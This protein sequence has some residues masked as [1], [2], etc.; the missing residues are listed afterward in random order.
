MTRIESSNQSTDVSEY[1]EFIVRV[2]RSAGGITLP[3][4]RRAIEVQNKGKH[5][6]F[7]PVTQADRE[8][9]AYLR[10]RIEA[11]FPSHSIVGE[12]FT[13]TNA[14]STTWYIDPIDGTR[15]FVTG[16]LHWG[17]LLAVYDGTHP[18]VGAMFQPFTQELFIASEEESWYEHGLEKRALQTRATTDLSQSMLGATSPRMFQPGAVLE[19]FNRLEDVV[20][21]TRFGGDCYLYGLLAI[22]SLDIVCESSLKRIDVIPVI[23]LVEKAGGVITDWQ[24]ESPVAGGN[25]VASA[26]EILH[27]KVLKVLSQDTGH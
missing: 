16:M 23:P 13:D 22:G 9:E 24:G 17:V 18:L 14:G 4:F 20:E 19:K 1:V 26:N 12:E 7:D 27:E 8:C 6:E 3:Y 10:N 21:L 15:A 2:I 5:G 11:A 25:I